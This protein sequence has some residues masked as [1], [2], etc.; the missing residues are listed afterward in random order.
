MN[1]A[2]NL[3]PSETARLSWARICELH[4]N[5]WVCLLDVENA[6]DGSLDS[7]RVIGHDRSMKRALSQLGMLEP[8]AVVAHTWK[9]PLQS[10]RIE[11][12]DAIR[13]ILRA[14]P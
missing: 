1:T 11:M 2:H 12:T 4:P 13:D 3:T 10:P 7:A 8:N 6:P 5:E 14:R 9:R